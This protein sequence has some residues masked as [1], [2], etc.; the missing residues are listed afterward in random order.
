ME[1]I[2][3]LCCCLACYSLLFVVIH[4]F[5]Y[6]LILFFFTFFPVMLYYSY[7]QTFSL[8]LSIL[9]RDG[10]GCHGVSFNERTDAGTFVLSLINAGTLTGTNAYDC[11]WE[12]TLGVQLLVC[13]RVNEPSSLI[14]N[15]SIIDAIQWG[16]V[17][18]WSSP[19]TVISG[20]TPM[21]FD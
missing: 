7:T 13:D 10:V 12:T 19:A 14:L 20:R 5:M 8:G 16:S 4:F 9:C 18:D 21:Q 1:P 6:F 15:I 2:N 11:V 17:N 3:C